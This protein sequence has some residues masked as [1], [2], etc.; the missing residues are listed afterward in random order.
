MPKYAYPSQTETK[1]S[2]YNN[3][4]VPEKSAFHKLNNIS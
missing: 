3:F 1:E 4:K 2:F